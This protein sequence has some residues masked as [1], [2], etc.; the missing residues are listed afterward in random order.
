MIDKA[1]AATMSVVVFLPGRGTP[2]RERQPDPGIGQGCGGCQQD[3]G[4]C[5][6]GAAGVAEPC[7][8]LRH[9]SS[10]LFSGAAVVRGG[11]AYQR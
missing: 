11:C 1:L 8:V 4:Q 6:L 10:L 7:A 5:E 3:N 9:A 2:A